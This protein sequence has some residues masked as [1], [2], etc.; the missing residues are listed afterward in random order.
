MHIRDLLDH[1]P[2]GASV[3]NVAAAF[4]LDPAKAEIAIDVMG[5]ELIDKIERNTLSRGGLADFVDLLGRPS[6][7]RALSDPG[8][9]AAPTIAAAGNGVLGVIVGDKHTSRGIA[10][11]A[12]R[13]S[14]LDEEALKRML[15]AVASLLVGALQHKAIRTNRGG[16]RQSPG[17]QPRRI[18]RTQ[19][20]AAS[21]RDTAA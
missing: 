20:I 13:A 7:G 9:L 11:K 8:R 6:A 16:G 15:P 17:V 3:R 10:V 2:G 12:A 19:S 18:A 4:G 5:Q 1:A 21:G 14:G